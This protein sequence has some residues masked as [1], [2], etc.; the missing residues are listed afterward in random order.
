M[1]LLMP[2][3]CAIYATCIQTTNMAQICKPYAN[4]LFN[5]CQIY[6]NEYIRNGAP[7]TKMHFSPLLSGFGIGFATAQ[8]RN[9]SKESD[10]PVFRAQNRRTSDSADQVSFPLHYNRE[11][12]PQI[13]SSLSPRSRL[14]FFV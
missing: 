11:K 1:L 10:K 6:A 3:M 7:L 14:F 13:H 12:N 5:I 4:Q 8:R 2:L 9:R